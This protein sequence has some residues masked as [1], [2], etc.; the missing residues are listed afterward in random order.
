M[1]TE[2]T[3]RY[4]VEENEIDI[5]ALIESLDGFKQSINEVKRFHNPD[6]NLD[7]K[8]KALEKGSFMVFLG[9]YLTENLNLIASVL[10]KEN[11]KLTAAILS[12]LVNSIKLKSHLQGN[13]PK[14]TKKV[15][16]GNNIEIENQNGQSIVINAETFNFYSNSN[17]DANLSTAF[18]GA[19]KEETLTSV[20][21]IDDKKEKLISVDQNEMLH[22]Q[23]KIEVIASKER[24]IIKEN[25]P[26]NATKLS[27]DDKIKWSFIY[28]G[29]K[30]NA[31]VEDKTFF[32]KIDSGEQFAKGDTLR[33]DLRIKQEYNE[34]VNSYINK[35]YTVMNVKDHI[36]R[37]KQT[38]LKLEDDL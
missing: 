14:A 15:E 31:K 11:V 35:S 27:W 30:I 34:D 20:E 22:L 4:E 19:R 23:N 38:K 17:I 32:E 16:K 26:V 29:N 9:L 7:I 13:Q 36:P 18:K 25:V 8:I 28:D 3:I 6:G 12:T 10:S 5:D 37:P 2:F 21:I 1:E 33:V 24:E